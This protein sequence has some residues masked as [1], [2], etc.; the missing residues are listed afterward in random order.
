MKTIVQ[1]LSLI[2]LTAHLSAVQAQVP[3]MNSYPAAN[4]VILLDFDGIDLS[5]TVWNYA[6]PFTCNPSGLTNDQIVETFNRVAEDYRPFN[7]NITTE[8]A[9]FTAAPIDQ[10]MRVIITTSYEWYG[11]GAG[12]VAYVNSF[13]WGDGTPCFVFSSLFGFNAKNIAEA[14]SH[15]AGHTLGLRHQSSYDGSC[16]K[17][18]DY[19]WGQG[20]G[21]IGW[22]PIMGAGYYQNLTLWHNGPNSF[23]CTNYQS[24]LDIISGSYNGFGFR[25]DDNANSFAGASAAVFDG[26]NNFTINGVIEQTSDIDYFQFTLPV[27]GN[28]TLDAIPYNV[29]TGNSGSDLDMN[30]QLYDQYHNLLGAYNPGNELSSIIDT[31]LQAGTYFISVDGEGN[32]YAPDYGSLG[33]YSLQAAFI[34]G[35]LLPVRK[36]ELH[37]HSEN[38]IHS[39]QWELNA[40][41]P[42][43]KQVIEFSQ[44]GKRFETLAETP[45]TDR[46]YAY[47]YNYAK[48]VQYRIAVTLENGKHYYSNVITFRPGIISKPQLLG[49]IIHQDLSINSPGIYQ[50]FI[51]DNNG[52]MVS[53]GRIEKGYS[54]IP[55]QQLVAGIYLIRFAADRQQWTEKFI[56]H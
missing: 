42:V 49:N 4:A 38:N 7:I 25:T 21:E 19:N 20:S 5:G 48:P 45:V 47:F 44:D 28:F 52:R 32:M 8:E 39:L 11:S 17:T 26:S 13:K 3:V 31:I 12:G 15:E 37:G 43:A 1:T 55:A 36:L 50:Y 30:V 46:A 16:N 18:S 14:A 27:F 34:D 2:L 40:D 23:G 9:K 6:G 53:K 35:S 54:T 41:E 24:D 10:R 56:K 22:A 33:S 51:M 29:G